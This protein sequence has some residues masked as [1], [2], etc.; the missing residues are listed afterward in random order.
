[1]DMAEGAIGGVGEPPTEEEE[2]AGPVVE[3]LTGDPV[4]VIK[5]ELA[6]L[7]NSLASADLASLEDPY[8]NRR[9]LVPVALEG[10]AAA[11]KLGWKK[12]RPLLLRVEDMIGED[13]F[14]E[15]KEPI[16]NKKNRLFSAR[17]IAAMVGLLLL[18]SAAVWAVLWL[19]RLFLP[20]LGD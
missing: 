1:M 8:A 16:F 17:D 10:V 15:T 6:N 4:E 20:S 7:V 14:P 19:I 2:M 9:G 13:Y 12:T 3:E 18:A 5:K 11:S